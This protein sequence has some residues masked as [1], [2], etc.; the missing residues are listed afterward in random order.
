ME[1][2]ARNSKRPARAGPSWRDVV[3]KRDGHQNHRYVAPEGSRGCVRRREEVGSKEGEIG[4]NPQVFGNGVMISVPHSPGLPYPPLSAPRFVHEPRHQLCNDPC[5]VM[6]YGSPSDCQGFVRNLSEVRQM[7]RGL[8]QTKAK[9][10][11]VFSAL[12]NERL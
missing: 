5:H 2:V 1:N 10:T 8:Y 12:Y 9:E 6:E 4:R 3:R 7:P 11:E